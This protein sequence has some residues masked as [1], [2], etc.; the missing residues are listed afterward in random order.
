[1]IT[2]NPTL[3]VAVEMLVAKYTGMYNKQDMHHMYMEQCSRIIAGS[4]DRCKTVQQFLDHIASIN[5]DHE[6]TVWFQ[7][8]RH[9]TDH[10]MQLFTEIDNLCELCDDTH[11]TESFN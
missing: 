8:Y 5:P 10:Y 6:S 3:Q 11:D 2:P 4:E 1:M 9:C 7:A